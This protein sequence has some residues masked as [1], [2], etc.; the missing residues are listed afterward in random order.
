[1]WGTCACGVAGRK[2]RG[3]APLAPEIILVCGVVEEQMQVRA[4]E[5]FMALVLHSFLL[6]SRVIRNDM[7]NAP[8]SASTK[9]QERI[10]ARPGRGRTIMGLRKKPLP[11]VACSLS[12]LRLCSVW[13]TST[14]STWWVFDQNA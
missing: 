3:S 12:R 2:V 5:F 1:M 7:L 6:N 9:R 8:L 11:W 13:Y 4:K 10:V 14:P